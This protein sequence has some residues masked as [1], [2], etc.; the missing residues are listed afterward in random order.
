MTNEDLD[1]ARALEAQR[2]FDA[3]HYN[4]VR[5]KMF[6]DSNAIV[7]AARLAREGWTPPEPVD[8]DIA[9]ADKLSYAW[10]VG[11]IKDVPN[12]ALAAIKRGRALAAEAKLGMVWKK[13]DGSGK[14]PVAGHH[15]VLARF[16][17]DPDYIGVYNAIIANWPNI[18]HY[19]EITPPAEDV[20]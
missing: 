12:L 7:A 11:E 1:K 9:E 20:A 6:W 4:T 10:H 18:T 15:L 14:S 2:L 13:H 17:S 5:N 8:P 16:K 3:N 19:C